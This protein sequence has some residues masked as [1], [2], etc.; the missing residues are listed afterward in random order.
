MMIQKNCITFTLIFM[1]SFFGISMVKA[2]NLK[3]SEDPNQ[4]ILDVNTMMTNSKNP[5]AIKAGTELQTAWGALNDKHKKLIISTSIL[6]IK[7]K[8]KTATHFT[9][10]FSTI[11]NAVTRKNI[12]AS[13]LDTLLFVTNYLLEDPKPKKIVAFLETTKIF[14][15]S[16]LLY[17]SN[18]NKLRVSGGSYSFGFVKSDEEGE[19]GEPIP[20][21]PVEE[22]IIPDVPLADAPT[23]DDTTQTQ[24]Q[25]PAVETPKKA[26]NKDDFFRDWDAPKEEVYQDW[27]TQSDTSGNLLEQTFMPSEQPRITGAYIRLAGVD[28][29]IVSKFDSTVIIGTKG[30]MMFSNKTFVGDGGK[31]DWSVAGMPETFIEL[32][33]YNFNVISAKFGAEDVK[34]N[35]PN[36]LDKSIKG[37]FE[38]KSTKHKRK[39]DIEYPRFMSYNS[40]VTI[41]NIGE[42]IKYK[43]GFSLNGNKVYSSSLDENPALIEVFEDNKLKFKALAKLFVLGDSLLTSDLV[44]IAIYQKDDS[45]THQGVSFHY[46]KPTHLLKLIKDK[47]GFR[48]TPYIDSYHGLEITCDMLSWNLQSKKMDFDMITAKNNNPALFESGEYFQHD[49]FDKLKGLYPFHP[50]IMIMSYAKEKDTDIFNIDDLILAYKVQAG[51]SKGA[52][53]ELVKKGFITYNSNNGEVKIKE[54]A[55]H[56]FKSNKGKKDYDELQVKSVGP[57]GTNASLDLENNILTVRGVDKLFL[58]KKL[59][60]YVLPKTKEINILQKRDMVFSGQVFSGHFLFQGREFRFD[61]DSFFVEMQ[62][63]DSLKLLIDTK[64]L[65]EKGNTK[66]A[67]LSSQIESTSGTLFINQHNNKSGKKEMPEYPMFKSN[68]GSSVYYNSPQTLGGVYEKRISF[69]VPPFMVDSLNSNVTNGIAFHGTM[70]SDGIFPDFQEILTVMPDMSLGYVRKTPKGG[71]PLYKGKGKYVG[72]ITLNNSGLRGHGTINY[73]STTLKSED[74]VYFPDSVYSV[75][76]HCE[77]KEGKYNDVFYPDLD[78]EQH[79]MKW[80]VYKDT[81]IVANFKNAFNLYKKS[82]QLDGRVLILKDGLWGDG[83]VSTRGS[84]T[85]SQMVR[86]EDQQYNAT[87]A[88]FTVESNDPSKPALRAA[89]VKLHFDFKA[90]HAYFSPEIEGYPSNEFPFLKYKTSMNGGDWDLE[91][92]MITFKM[93]ENGNFKK[94]YFRSYATD[95]DSLYFNAKNAVYDIKNLTLNINGVPEIRV[96]DATIFPNKEEVSIKASTKLQPLVNAKIEMDTTSKFHKLHSGNIR[97]TSRSEFLGDAIYDYV[98]GSNDTM[99]IKMTPFKFEE[100]ESHKG[101]EKHTVSKSSIRPQDTFLLAPRIFYKGDIKLK[102]NEKHL[103]LD[104]FVKLKLKGFKTSEEWL[105]Y[106]YFL[107]KDSIEVKIDKLM[108]DE[109]TPLTTGIC[110]TDGH[111][112]LYP[113]FLSRKRHSIDLQI[114]E[115]HG[116]K[117]RIKNNN[118]FTIGTDEKYTGEKLEGNIISYND[119]T[120]TMKYQGKINIFDYLYYGNEFIVDAS[121][122]GS[123][124]LDSNKYIFNTMMALTLNAPPKA[125]AL[126]ATQIAD[127]ASSNQSPT[128]ISDTSSYFFSNLANITGDKEAYKYEKQI[129]VDYKPLHKVAKSLAN[130]FVI[131]DVK[132]IWSNELQAWHSEGDIGIANIYKK[133]VNYKVKGYIEIKKFAKGDKYHIFLEPAPDHWYYMVFEFNRLSLSSSDQEFHDLVA[134]KSKGKTDNG[135]YCF[136]VADPQEKLIFIKNFTRHYLHTETPTGA[137]N[138]DGTPNTAPNTTPGNAP[139]HQASP[140]KV[141]TPTK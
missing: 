75:G 117:L 21:I 83:T 46:D 4:F 5:K 47:Y 105:K 17:K 113:T 56:Y 63:L 3:L 50:L 88:F 110:I 77:I 61:Y 36:Y 20:E 49:I 60:V 87:E 101:I 27:G 12:P 67:Q 65:D 32:S 126:M 39:R 14:M 26:E 134:A 112:K 37:V 141:I 10:Y 24:A 33:K 96:T 84:H 58:S 137:T 59:N 111:Y 91:K 123:A 35:S 1:I 131:T 13:K 135:K 41:K 15:E 85:T 19:E 118:E 82:V 44:S 69:E 48:H 57:A 99:K 70:H 53:K 92:Q 81:M 66:V 95:Q 116:S 78:I 98:N 120:N 114:F 136:V 45:I 104:G 52:M 29:Q 42:N 43:G 129:K 119:S 127:Q 89:N 72:E 9:P 133:D 34:M 28:L 8:C 25:T 51:A 80:H 103:T 106:D 71:F 121:T 30:S 2:Q 140:S 7:K 124:N 108:Y 73:M 94:S 79:D 62:N 18:F 128:A 122:T 115:A 55:W 102:A 107:H 11:A 68:Q 22:P 97:I 16:D 64:D 139:E 40:D 90:K 125:M 23:T 86:F 6:M 130:K 138:Q 54:K 109:Q 132:L 74:F 93:P 38:F 100:F 31:F 76:T